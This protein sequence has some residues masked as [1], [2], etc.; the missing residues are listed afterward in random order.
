MK[1]KKLEIR[2]SESEYDQ[3]KVWAG[4]DGISNFVRTKLGLDGELS[5]QNGDDVRTNIQEVV[6]DAQKLSGQTKEIEPVSGQ[7]HQKS[8]GK[9]IAQEMAEDAIREVRQRG[10]PNQVCRA[11][12]HRFMMQDGRMTCE[13]CGMQA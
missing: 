11:L 10:K 12:G 7:K 6:E 2:V 1:L 9:S 13:R 3:V 5:G 8:R 4:K